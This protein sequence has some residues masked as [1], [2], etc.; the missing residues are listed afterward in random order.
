[1]LSEKNSMIPIGYKQ[2]IMLKKPNQ[3]K[4]PYRQNNT[5]YIRAFKTRLEK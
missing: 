2:K 1:M 3:N 4:K 5:M